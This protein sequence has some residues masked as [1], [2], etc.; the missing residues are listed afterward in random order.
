MADTELQPRFWVPLGVTTIFGGGYHAAEEELLLD[1]E[2]PTG[3][4]KFSE[5]ISCVK[6]TG[7]PCV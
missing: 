6:P 2:P 3:G 1:E 5:L 4:T 7:A